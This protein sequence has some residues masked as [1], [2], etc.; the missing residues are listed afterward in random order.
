MTIKIGFLLSQYG[1]NEIAKSFIQSSNEF[2]ARETNVDIIGF[3]SN[4]SQ[5]ISHPT[6]ATM[7]INEAFDYDGVV[8]ATSI[9][10]AEKLARFPGP[11]E[12]YLYL[13]KLDWEKRSFEELV[14]LF[15]SP[16]LEIITRTEE[17]RKVFQQCWNRPVRAVIPDC[18]IADFV[19]LASS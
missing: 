16:R 1:D 18:N 17:D 14:G 12:R 19:R 4:Q 2:L 3:V 9:A 7:N 8:V 5:P 15:N 11:Q 13:W 10:M 6:F